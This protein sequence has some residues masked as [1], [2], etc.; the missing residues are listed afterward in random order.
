[1]KQI[2]CYLKGNIYEHLCNT[3]KYVNKSF[4][5]W[6]KCA[7]YFYFS[8]P[9]NKG[10]D[11]C[12]IN[13]VVESVMSLRCASTSARHV[14]LLV[15]YTSATSAGDLHVRNVNR[16]FTRQQRLPVIYTS[17]TSAGDLHVRNVCWW[18]ATIVVW[19]PR[20]FTATIDAVTRQKREETVENTRRTD[21]F[22]QTR[23][24]RDTRHVTPDSVSF[25]LK[26]S[27]IQQTNSCR[28]RRQTKSCLTRENELVVQSWVLNTS[29]YTNASTLYIYSSK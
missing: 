1:M 20:R 26:R 18:S 21:F 22:W 8:L 23:E 19:D 5:C 12:V 16:L 7:S 6:R 17:A 15:I 27:N 25:L 4:T 24:E 13:Y 28:A 9:L 29:E 3:F 11:L 2:Q 14:R 10:R